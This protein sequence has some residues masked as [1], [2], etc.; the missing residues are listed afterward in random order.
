MSTHDPPEKNGTAV[1]LTFEDNL[2]ALTLTE[3]S[4]EN[5]EI[6]TN[7]SSDPVDLAIG[8]FTCFPRLPLELRRKIWRTIAR[9]P[10]VIVLSETA[11]ARNVGGN[12]GAFWYTSTTVSVQQCRSAQP[13]VLRVCHESR[14][15]CLELYQLI[16]GT[17]IRNGH[18]SLRQS[19]RLLQWQ[20]SVVSH[21]EP[22]VFFNEVEDTLLLCCPSPVTSKRGSLPNW[23][24]FWYHCPPINSLK[25]VAFNIH[26]FGY[27]NRILF[28]WYSASPGELVRF[29]EIHNTIT[30][31]IL[32]VS[33]QAKLPSTKGEFEF[34]KL[35]GSSYTHA[36]AA[37]NIRLDF[38]M[39][40]DRLKH[41]FTARTKALCEVQRVGTY[42]WVK[43]G[44]DGYEK[45]ESPSP[46]ELEQE[47]FVY[48]EIEI[49]GITRGGIRL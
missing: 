5:P 15:E 33:K 19:F 36:R 20:S 48:P 7:R 40:F 30:K 26:D 44:L 23:K 22:T 29:F 6:I 34:V 8:T 13:P 37:E 42:R 4:T 45:I 39:L 35:V 43:N 31:V 25:T 16:F 46:L 32:V 9:L 27:M 17:H 18:H 49:M 14:M 24:T 12:N 3:K 47:T 10:R 11:P 21:H 28:D 41:R 38:I 1:A 2:N